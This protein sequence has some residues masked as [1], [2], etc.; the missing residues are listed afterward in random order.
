[1][2]PDRRRIWLPLVRL[3]TFFI[4]VVLACNVVLQA[5]RSAAAS[6]SPDP[7]NTDDPMPRRMKR[8]ERRFHRL[9]ERFIDTSASACAIGDEKT[10]PVANRSA[11]SK[12]LPT[13]AA[14]PGVDALGPS[15]GEAA[16]YVWRL[17][18]AAREMPE[19][20][21][22]QSLGMLHWPEFRAQLVT[23]LYRRCASDPVADV[24]DVFL[25]GPV[26]LFDGMFGLV[27]GLS[28]RSAVRTWEEDEERGVAVSMLD[29]QRGPRTERIYTVFMR[30]WAEREEK[31][32]GAFSESR[33]NTFGFQDRTEGADL[34][35]LADD[36][37]K[38][39]WDV[40]RRTY[41]AQ[42]IGESEA[43]V[44]EGAWHFGRWSGV[45]FAVLPPFMAAYVYYRGFDKKFSMGD[46]A[47]RIG[48]EPVTEFV[49]RKRDRSSATALELTVK[50]FPVG[51]IASAG[52]Y[53]GRYGMD[54]VGIGTSISAVRAT[55]ELQH[56]PAPR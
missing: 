19:A 43:Q 52:L 49:H 18:A 10:G 55:L 45:D 17:P 11:M 40:L 12:S 41:M 46:L 15:T 29:I 14:G 51:M 7:Q 27:G 54:F 32:L 3:G 20:L 21:L 8:L 25:Q 44:R 4:T 42:Y 37:R 48:I 23:D 5:F 26:M 6:F 53:G 35:K 2:D 13:L 33:A 28:A 1:M 50:G 38:V 9:L 39:V 22:P 36:Q 24:G 31:Y 16:R 30:E 34:H 56:E 47:L